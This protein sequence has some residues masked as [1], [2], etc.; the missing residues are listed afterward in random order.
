MSEQELDLADRVV[1]MCDGSAE[2]TVRTGQHALT[3][4]ANSFIH[5]NVAES[6]ASVSLRLSYD[7]RTA[8]AS[9][10][11]DPSASDLDDSLRT[12]VART[13]KAARLRPV[14]PE[15]PG[16]AQ[17]APITFTG[18]YDRRTAEASPGERAALVRDFVE[19]A[20]DLETAGFCETVGSVVAF[21]NSAGQRVTGETSHAT[22]DGVART[23]G[24][25]AS[26]RRTAS[27]L[28]DLDGVVLGRRA[29]TRALAAV[30]AGDVEPG[31]YEVV[32]EPSCVA[33]LVFFIAWQ[34]FNARSVAEGR[35]FVA[36]G[37]QQFD[38]SV[39]LWD[40][41]ADRRT[42]SLPFDD[43]GTPKQRLDLVRDGVSV[44][45]A[46][47]LRTAKAGGTTS[48][49][50]G[51]E[52]GESEGAMACN[53][54]LGTGSHD[55]DELVSQME[56][57][58]LVTDFWYTRI[59]DPRTLVVTGLTRN[60]VFLVENGTVVRPVANLRFTQSYVDAIGPDHVLGIGSVAE[61]HR[62]YMASY[63]VPALRL[64]SWNFTGGARG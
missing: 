33:D 8:N 43:E 28:A 15:W 9:T 49:G 56:R 16:L 40:D 2:V 25:D 7:G 12:L 41:A 42:V 22:L 55:M 23:S 46:E 21:A 51:I 37:E 50:H 57:G 29:A 63:S 62:Q 13:A 19:A 24:A 38:R 14:D 35:S 39:Q 20:G 27:S 53:L 44:G 59:L 61:M 32:L 64:A 54:L 30:G 48:T 5:Q 10:T 4:F 17:P 52:G 3:R 11:F 31:H 1:A 34:G 58:L 36:L 18:S 26:A 60:G 47:D 6:V 45:L